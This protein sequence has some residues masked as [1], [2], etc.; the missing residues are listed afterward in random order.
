MIS[1]GQLDDTEKSVI[2]Q[3]ID[4]RASR[5]LDF[6]PHLDLSNEGKQALAEHGR[7]LRLSR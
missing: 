3:L 7:A 5:T 1:R 6:K 2:R 4:P